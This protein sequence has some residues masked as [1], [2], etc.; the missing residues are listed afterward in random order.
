LK[1][2]T[3]TGEVWDERWKGIDLN[4]F[5]DRSFVDDKWTLFHKS[6]IEKYL[7]KLKSGSVFLEAGCGLG[8]WCF[9]ASEKYN[10][11]S[12]GVD[13]AEETIN[14]LNEHNP[15]KEQVGFVVDNLND[16]KLEDGLCDMFISLGVIEHNRDSVPMLKTL[17]RL[18]KPG[19]VGV[20]TVPNLYC[21]HVITRPIL[22]FLGK[23]N[24]GYEKSFSN[25]S[26]KKIASSVGFEVIEDGL[27]P[28][29]ELFGNTSINLP[30][31]GRLFKSL[32]FF[33]ERRQKI[34]GFLAFVVVRKS[35]A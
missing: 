6:L 24:I 29:G 33:L 5:H 2:K 7:N 22:Q 1:Q 11:R 21:M 19:G 17:Y 13:V 34:F 9:Y 12:I 3:D 4:K 25:K 8:Q 31:V 10:T 15:R 27:L 26:L 32:S 28:T 16:S 14:K 30:L 20:V 18:T 23:W 35:R